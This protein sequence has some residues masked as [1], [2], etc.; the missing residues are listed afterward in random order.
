MLNKRKD[1]HPYKLHTDTGTSVAKDGGVMAPRRKEI[2]FPTSNTVR[3]QLIGS[4]V[5]GKQ[6]VM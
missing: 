3:W 6:G 4:V 5:F 2:F 1:A